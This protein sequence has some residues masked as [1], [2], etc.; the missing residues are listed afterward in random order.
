L[1]FPFTYYS[2]GTQ[3]KAGAVSF[4][5]PFGFVADIAI[6]LISLFLIYKKKYKFLIIFPSLVALP[7]ILA[8]LTL[9]FHY[10]GTIIKPKPPII[11]SYESKIPLRVLDKLVV[12]VIPKKTS[13]SAS[14]ALIVVAR[15]VN[16]SDKEGVVYMMSCSYGDNWVVDNPLVSVDD[17]VTLCDKNTPVNEPLQPGGKIERY[18]YIHVSGQAN[19]GE[20]TFRLGFKLYNNF[21]ECCRGEK[22]K[23]IWSSPVTITLTK[24]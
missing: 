3:C 8:G 14:E 24:N 5:S 12:E 19:P 17:G 16:I 2:W 15:I 9:I 23:V 4:F 10:M 11:V 7:I 20:I 22:F 1:G 6:W 13:I 21:K 18:L